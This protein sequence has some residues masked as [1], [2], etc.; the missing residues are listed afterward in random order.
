ME[1]GLTTPLALFVFLCFLKKRIPTPPLPP[2][3]CTLNLIF[4]KAEKH[5]EINTNKEE[6]EGV[7]DNASAFMHLNIKT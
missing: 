1:V 7:H 4:K 2:P 3:R 5:I 6:V